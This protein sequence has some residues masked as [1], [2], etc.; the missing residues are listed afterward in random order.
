M[1]HFD[2]LKFKLFGFAKQWP[3]CFSAERFYVRTCVAQQ[4]AEIQTLMQH[5]RVLKLNFFKNWG[6]NC[7]ISSALN[8]STLLLA[9]LQNVGQM[10]F[11]FEYG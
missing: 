9:G 2:T 1:G 4:G 11:L 3:L 10:T 7:S 8:V 6:T 5:L